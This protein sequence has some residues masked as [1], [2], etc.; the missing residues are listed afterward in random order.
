MLALVRAARRARGFVESS[1]AG[2]GKFHISGWPECH[3]VSRS[4]PGSGPLSTPVPDNHRVPPEAPDVPAVRRSAARLRFAQR[5]TIGFLDPVEDAF[6]LTAGLRA[7]GHP[8]S[9]HLGRESAPAA[10]PA[11]LYA[12]VQCGDEVVST[13]LPVREEYVE[14]FRTERCPQ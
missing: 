7:L 4:R 13:S 3:S 9:F 14:I 1:R 11:G 12:W 2:G 5:L 8:A 6:Y 10:A